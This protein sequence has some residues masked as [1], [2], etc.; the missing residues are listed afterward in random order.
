MAISS[1]SSVFRPSNWLKGQEC[2]SFSYLGHI[3]ML[4]P[5]ANG[6]LLA[7]KC[8]EMKRK[9]HD[10]TI[11]SSISIGWAHMSEWSGGARTE[12]CPR[13]RLLVVDH[14][15]IPAPKRW[16]RNIG[17]EKAHRLH[18]TC[19][20]ASTS[21]YLHH[22]R[23][24]AIGLFRHR[25]QWAAQCTISHLHVGPV[26]HPKNRYNESRWTVSLDIATLAM[27]NA[28]YSPE[29]S[30]QHAICPP[31]PPLSTGPSQHPLPPS[32]NPLLKIWANFYS[33]CLGLM[34]MPP[35]FPSWSGYVRESN[36]A[37]L[38]CSGVLQEGYFPVKEAEELDRI[39]VTYL[40]RSHSLRTQ[41]CR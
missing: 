20:A 21:L 33:T 15:N 26:I 4:V 13:R 38:S 29:P 8:Q 40:L 41:R 9:I 14:A 10:V 17:R 34:P 24:Y 23:G 16:F 32:S 27:S 22:Q 5:Y 2:M 7:L 6:A 30:I 11:C 1:P 36:V 39:Y 19:Q 25:S 37:R 12:L 35:S 28:Y 18:Y 31:N 3:A